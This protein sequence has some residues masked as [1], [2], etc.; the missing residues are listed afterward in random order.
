[1]FL[2]PIATVFVAASI[3][4]PAGVIMMVSGRTNTVAT[5]PTSSLAIVSGG[6]CN[7]CAPH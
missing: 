6:T 7:L 4:E 3:S 5:L 1:L 2:P